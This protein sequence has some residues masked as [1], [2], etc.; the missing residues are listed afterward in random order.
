MA[1]HFTALR[2]DFTRAAPQP[3]DHGTDDQQ[4]HGDEQQ[5]E[6]RETHGQAEQDHHIDDDHD[7]VL[8]QRRE[9]RTDRRFDLISIADDSRDELAGAGA[10]EV[11]ERQR[12]EVAEEPHAQIADNAFLNGHAAERSEI[13]RDVLEQQRDEQNDDDVAQRNLRSAGLKQRSCDLVEDRLHLRAAFDG[14]RG[15]S[16]QRA[17]E[18]DQQHEG[19]AVEHG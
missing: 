18:R 10:L 17:Q 8:Q 11:T 6:Q 15:V 16:E 1:R 5:R 13:R 14:K 19:E 7:A 2:G 3:I 4:Q 9:R 12:L